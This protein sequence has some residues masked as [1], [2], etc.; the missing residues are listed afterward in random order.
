MRKLT[1]LF[2][3]LTILTTNIRCFAQPG[4]HEANTS[5]Y[6]ELGGNALSYSIN[7]DHLIR[8]QKVFAVAPR[9]GFSYTPDLLDDKFGI[10]SF[11]FE[12][13]GLIPVSGQSHFFELGP[14]FTYLLIFGRITTKDNGGILTFRLGY[15][16]QR[17]DGGFMFRAGLLQMTHR[18]GDFSFNGK[19][20]LTWAGISC[21]FAF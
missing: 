8:I 20:T 9:T 18:F 4:I 3:F 13:N 7:I 2:T 16:Y 5:Y 6:V 12:L 17:T 14:G 19:S 11:P 10:T 1:L 21:G 15:R